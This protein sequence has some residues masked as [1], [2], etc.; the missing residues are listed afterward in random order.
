M[1]NK[2]T[3]T[4]LFDVPRELVWKALTDTKLLTQD[5]GS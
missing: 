5:K 4:H 2:L 3:I 1:A